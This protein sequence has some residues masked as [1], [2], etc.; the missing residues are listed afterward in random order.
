VGQK[1]EAGE[2]EHGSSIQIRTA[3]L[4]GVRR[5]DKKNL[6]KREGQWTEEMT[7]ASKWGKIL[8]QKRWE[9]LTSV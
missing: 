4:D 5:H 6:A 2:R 3:F 1:R 8:K 7:I 9:K